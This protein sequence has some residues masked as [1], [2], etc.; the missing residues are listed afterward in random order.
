MSRF[1]LFDVNFNVIDVMRV[2]PSALEAPETPVVTIG[3][4]AMLMMHTIEIDAGR[5]FEWFVYCFTD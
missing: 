2:Q 1:E 4:L 5:W 3:S